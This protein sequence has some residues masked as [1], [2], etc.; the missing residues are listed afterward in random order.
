[1]CH[2]LLGIA[3]CVALCGAG[4]VFGQ[5]GVILTGQGAINRSMAGAS[6]AAPIDASGALYWNP[7]AITGLNRSEMEFGLEG[8]YPQTEVSSTVA[9]GPWGLEHLPRR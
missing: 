9:A 1:M 5:A 7:A 8:L 2:R 3:L 4:T 6:T